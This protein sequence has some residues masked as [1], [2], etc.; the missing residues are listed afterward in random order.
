LLIENVLLE[1]GGMALMGAGQ[2][3]SD[4]LFKLMG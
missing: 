2:Q 3:M 4:L 1:N